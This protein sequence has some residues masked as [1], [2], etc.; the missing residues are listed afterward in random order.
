MTKPD[1]CSLSPTDYFSLP[2]LP[3]TTNSFMLS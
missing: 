3:I 2:L 1:D